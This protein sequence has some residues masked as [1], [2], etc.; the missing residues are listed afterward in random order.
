[1]KKV[2]CAAVAVFT[3]FIFISGCSKG[4]DT[5]SSLLTETA[6][7]VIKEKNGDPYYI[8][9]KVSGLKPGTKL[10]GEMQKLIDTGVYEY[11]WGDVRKIYV[12]KKEEAAA[13]AKGD[14]SI[15]LGGQITA[16]LAVKKVYLD[17]I[18]KIKIKKNE[19]E[20]T[21]IEK[22]EPSDLYDIITA[23]QEAKTTL[24]EARQAGELKEPEEK[25]ITLIKEN[26]TWRVK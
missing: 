20:V 13:Y 3:L 25:Q 14:I 26:E 9:V 18:L 5:E 19:A 12:P 17:R 24:E 10:G 23:D 6:A 1:V 11:E 8:Y 15:N 22:Y 2:T 21:Y 16:E 7:R 4:P